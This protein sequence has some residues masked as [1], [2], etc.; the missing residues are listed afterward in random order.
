MVY[1]RYDRAAKFAFA[2][3]VS[4]KMAMLTRPLRRDRTALC[5]SSRRPSLMLYLS[6]SLGVTLLKNERVKERTKLTVNHDPRLKERTKLAKNER[7]LPS[8]TTFS[9]F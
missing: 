5:N 3:F 9:V 4:C 2:I 7:P 6:V 8:I 1:P